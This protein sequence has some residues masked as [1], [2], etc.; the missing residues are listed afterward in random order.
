[1]QPHTSVPVWSMNAPAFV[2]GI[3]YSD[4]QSYRAFG[5]PA[6]MVTDTAFFRNLAYHTP[7]DTPDRLDYPRMAANRRRRRPHRQS[8][9]LRAEKHLLLR[10][11][12]S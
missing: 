9:T 5:M 12:D 1:M 3:D 4:H 6:V 8:A 7:E 11:A 2:E 10:R